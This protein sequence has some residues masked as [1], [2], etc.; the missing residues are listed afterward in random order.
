MGALTS[1]PYSFTARPWE[2]RQYNSFDF[3]DTLLAKIRID[4]RG[5]NILRILP[6][7]DSVTG[8]E[9]II[10]RVR[11][12]YD[13][14][15]RQR[16]NSVFLRKDSGDFIKISWQKLFFFLLRDYL[17]A[18]K[19][20]LP[21]I[22]KPNK[23]ID[24]FTANI[25]L[26]FSKKVAPNLVSKRDYLQLVDFRQNFIFDNLFRFKKTFEDMLLVGANMR[27][28]LPLLNYHIRKLVLHENVR[29]LT[30]L[31]HINDTFPSFSLGL[32][33]KEFWKVLCGNSSYI[34]HQKR[35]LK[36]LKVFLSSNLISWKFLVEHKL[37]NAAIIL[38][39]VAELSFLEQGAVL[40]NNLIMSESLQS[41]SNIDSVFFFGPRS[42]VF[43]SHPVS[44]IKKYNYI[45]PV[46][47]PWEEGGSFINTF[48]N[49]RKSE[50]FAFTT[51]RVYIRSF[52]HVLYSFFC[53][54]ELFYAKKVS[55]VSTFNFGLSLNFSITAQK[56]QDWRFNSNLNSLILPSF[57]LGGV[58]FCERNLYNVDSLTKASKFLMLSSS[59]FKKINCYA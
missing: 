15:A 34:R 38:E 32:S 11:F 29:V 51:E 39:N 31:E 53:F 14:L 6:V 48:G 23:F 3:F 30:L 56:I 27:F 4:I 26:Q 43:T 18:L 50:A 44:H 1:K 47:T 42:V 9:F 24:L 16:V 7:Y 40:K 37:G 55:S 22:I 10:D 33:L 19:E 25:L 13:A 46:Y 54:L 41:D 8:E 35:A 59:R 5:E 2:L 45:L 52:S 20:G 49:K 12:F 58:F 36:N 21:L 17:L 28:V 57:S